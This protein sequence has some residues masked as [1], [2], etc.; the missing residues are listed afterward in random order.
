MSLVTLV[1][2]MVVRRSLGEAV[3]AGCYEAQDS[4]QDMG[5]EAAEE[6]DWESPL[7][8]EMREEAVLDDME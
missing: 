4:I 2:E 8:V 5:K 1:D 7:V 3:E 6:M